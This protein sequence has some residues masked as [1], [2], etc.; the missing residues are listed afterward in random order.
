LKK[1]DHSKNKETVPQGE[2]GENNQDVI[3]YKNARMPIMPKIAASNNRPFQ[4]IGSGGLVGNRYVPPQW[5]HLVQFF[6]T[7][8]PQWVQGTRLLMNCFSL[9][10]V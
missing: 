6:A 1:R 10:F 8:P 4:G 5:G 2:Q 3:T 7:F 9:F